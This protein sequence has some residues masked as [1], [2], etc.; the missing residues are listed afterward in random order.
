MNKYPRAFV[1][2]VLALLF[3]FGPVAA[4]ARDTGDAA[5]RVQVQAQVSGEDSQENANSL[6]AGR[7]AE[8]QELGADGTSTST[9][10]GRQEDSEDNDEIDLNQGSSGER[11][12]AS[13]TP[14]AERGLLRAAE[15]HDRNELRQFARAALQE[16]RN[17]ENVHISSTTVRTEYPT[18]ARFLG[19]V[20]ANVKAQVDV[21]ADGTVS[22]TFPWYAFLFATNKGE[23]QSQVQNS[24]LS[25]LGISTTT[26]GAPEGQLTPQQQATVLD[27]II[28]TLRGLFGGATASR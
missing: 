19:V 7:D 28:S 5:V 15:V 25:T 2:T 22:V 21:N 6:S 12:Q 18:R 11:G 13:T 1:G 26:A 16:D 27:S 24:V 3:G 17:I 14:A 20:P 4:L 10:I 23:L 8:D 9:G